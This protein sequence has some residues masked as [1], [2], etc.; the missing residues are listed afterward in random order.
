[1]IGR[2]K[3]LFSFLPEAV[4]QAAEPLAY[5]RQIFENCLSWFRALKLTVCIRGLI[6]IGD[7]SCGLADNLDF[8][9]SRQ[10]EHEGGSSLLHGH[11]HL[12]T[13][14]GVFR[15]PCEL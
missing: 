5:C 4:C 15:G 8:W 12:F 11:P 13:L 3:K 6:F 14:W 2:V 1:M 9:I 7:F 10:W